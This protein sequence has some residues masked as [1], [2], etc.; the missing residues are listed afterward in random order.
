MRKMKTLYIVLYFLANSTVGFAQ[1]FW[2][3]TPNFPAGPKTAF[4]GM[5]DSVLFVGTAEGIWKSK[6]E[7]N[8]WE[9]AL[10]SPYVFGLCASSSGTLIAGGFGKIFFSQDKGT[11]WDS[12]KVASDL[13]VTKIVEGKTAHFILSPAASAMKQALWAMGFST[14]MEI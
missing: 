2:L 14:V 9:K 13:P 7:G 11:T 1:G 6:N 10:T 8:T 12:V 4:V 3:T 5:E